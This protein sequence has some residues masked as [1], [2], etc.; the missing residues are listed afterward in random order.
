MAPFCHLTKLLLIEVVIIISQINWCRGH[1]NCNDTHGDARE[2]KWRG[3]WRMQW[4]ASTLHTTSEH[5]VSSITTADAH[6]SAASSRL[7]RRPRRPIQMDW[8][9][10]HERL[11]LV[12]VRVPSRFNRPLLIYWWR[13]WSIASLFY[14]F[15]WRVYHF[16]LPLVYLVSFIS[17]ILL[18]STIRYF[19]HNK[20]YV[21]EIAMLY[22]CDHFSICKIFTIFHEIL[23]KHYHISWSINAVILFP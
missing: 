18:I 21:C 19:P 1:L 16:T 10:S 13:P 23:H 7:N 15:F 6:T 9:V 4:V 11:N 8:S 5:G 14:P 17:L 2:G 3:N 20:N 22:K 12:S